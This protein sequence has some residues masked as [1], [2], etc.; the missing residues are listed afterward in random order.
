M[1]GA[2][3]FLVSMDERLARNL[4]IF[5]I[6]LCII[7]LIGIIA[8]KIMAVAVS[9][10]IAFMLIFTG[11]VLCFFSYITGQKKKMAWIKAV[12]PLALGLF[13]I[14]K[15]FALIVVLGFAIFIYFIL[16][17]VTS[18]TLALEL[19]PWS[20]WRL[21][22]IN[23]VFSLALAGLFILFWPYST[24]WYLGWMVGISLIL[25]GIFFIALSKGVQIDQ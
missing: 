15:P 17:G 4:K 11:L 18:M 21:L 19:K 8:P 3:S 16:E 9:I 1:N 23:G 14:L 22:F 5:G 20:G 10:V 7:G 24:H 6:V 12:S 25:N 2:F 13:I